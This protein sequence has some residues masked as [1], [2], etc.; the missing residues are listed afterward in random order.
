M[1]SKNPLVLKIAEGAPGD[2]LLKYL[3]AK[4]LAFT[5]EEYLES[6]VFVLPDPR[7]REAARQL[8]GFVPQAVKEQYVQKRDAE[9]RV[10][11]FILQEALEVGYFNVMTLIIHNQSVPVEFILRIAAQAK[12]AVLE[13]LLENQIRLIAYPEILER[14]EANSDCNSFIRGRVR[15]L[16]GYKGGLIDIDGRGGDRSAGCGCEER[17]KGKGSGSHPGS[18]VTMSS[19]QLRLWM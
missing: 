13:T 18:P 8:L 3:L 14:M 16:R 6:L 12:A 2:E 7:R 5:D 4:Q 17:G 15:E 1:V 19:P 9:T 11:D 10:I